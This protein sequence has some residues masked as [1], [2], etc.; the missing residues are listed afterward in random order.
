MYECDAHRLLEL[1]LGHIVD[2]GLHAFNSFINRKG[3][4]MVIFQVDEQYRPDVFGDDKVDGV[5]PVDIKAQ[6]V[7]I[8]ALYIIIKGVEHR[9]VGDVF[10][11]GPLVI[12][13]GIH[14]DG[15][16][17]ILS[18][19]PDAVLVVIAFLDTETALSASSWFITKVILPAK[20]LM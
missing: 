17:D 7:V 2:H 20:G 14:A 12:D 3:G 9:G 19:N 13:N 5:L 8:A 4:I 1:K 16:G 6:A 11:D 18:R 15:R 10:A